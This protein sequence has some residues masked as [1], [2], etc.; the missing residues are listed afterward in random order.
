MLSV[1]APCQLTSLSVPLATS[2]S[3]SSICRR[4]SARRC[5]S[6]WVKSIWSP[7]PTASYCIAYIWEEEKKDNDNHYLNFCSFQWCS[8][9]RNIC[10]FSWTTQTNISLPGKTKRSRDSLPV[11]W[12]A[13]ALHL[14]QRE[15]W[16]TSMFL[17]TKSL[18]FFLPLEAPQLLS[19]HCSSPDESVKLSCFL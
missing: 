12:Y 4:S 3:S 11:M 9:M 14:A 6:A 19:S 13:P 15:L 8:E 2:S 17:L 1:R 10:L 5:F 16:H 18:C 7:S